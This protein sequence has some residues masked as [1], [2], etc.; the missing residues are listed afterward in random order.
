MRAAQYSSASMMVSTRTVLVGVGG[1]VGE[2]GQGG[3]V[4]IKFEKDAVALNIEGAHV[5]LCPSMRSMA[6]P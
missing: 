6:P 2:V 3:V 1:V 5:V 4:V